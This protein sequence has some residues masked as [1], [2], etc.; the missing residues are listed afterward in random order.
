MELTLAESV[1]LI[2]LD[3][4]KGSTGFTPV[5][6]GLA[7]ALLIDLGRLGALR[8]EGKELHPVEVTIA[9]PVLAR[10]YGVI[11]ASRKPVAPRHGWDG[12][13]VTSNP[14]P[15]RWPANWSNAES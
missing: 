11:S 3:D 8:H 7:G 13:P 14:S 15:A 12:Y 2:A 4:A 9:H 1:L 5:D 6:P 10:A